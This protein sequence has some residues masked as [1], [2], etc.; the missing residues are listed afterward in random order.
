MNLDRSRG[1]GVD[2]LKSSRPVEF[3]VKTPEEAEEMFDVLT[4]QKGSTVLRMFETFI[5]EENFKKGVRNYLNKHKYKNTHSS[6]LW[7]ELSGETE[8]DLEDILPTWI[9]QE[10]YPII[11]VEHNE[12]TNFIFSQSKFLID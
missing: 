6:D 1:F 8:Y 12:N 4:Y 2:S 10:G 3:E 9:K 5:G 7:T 11:S